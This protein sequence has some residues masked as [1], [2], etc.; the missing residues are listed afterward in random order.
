MYSQYTQTSVF[1]ANI[2]K[3]ITLY[4]ENSYPTPAMFLLSLNILEPTDIN[5]L[6]THF[7]TC[8]EMLIIALKAFLGF[9]G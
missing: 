5:L 6:K 8:G 2:S 9:P 4:L 3:G 7:K 1:M